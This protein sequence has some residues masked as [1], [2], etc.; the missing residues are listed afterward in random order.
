[1]QDVR[2]KMQDAMV[3]SAKTL[4]RDGGKESIGVGL[5]DV[6]AAKYR[7]SD[8]EMCKCCNANVL[9]MMSTQFYVTLSTWSHMSR[10]VVRLEV[11]R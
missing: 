6:C 4:L 9:V 1:M 11:L 10:S 7:L 2:C 5:S 3:G 8:D